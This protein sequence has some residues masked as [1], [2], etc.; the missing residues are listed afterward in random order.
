MAKAWLAVAAAAIVM[1]L[2]TVGLVAALTW[3]IVQRHKVRTLKDG[4]PRVSARSR[5]AGVLVA[6]RSA[7]RP[8]ATD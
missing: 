6:E 3:V 5:G 2:I 8:R 1:Q 4:R 7:R